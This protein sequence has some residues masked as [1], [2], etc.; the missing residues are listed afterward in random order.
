[1]SETMDDETAGVENRSEIVFLYDAE[2]ANPNGNPLSA[3]DRPRIDENTQQAVVTDVRLKRFIRDQLH[4]DNLGVYIRNPA[5]EGEQGRTRDDLF[6]DLLDTTQDEIKEMDSEELFDRF[7]EKATDVRYFGATLSFDD[8]VQDALEE[9]DISTPQYTGP[10]QFSHGRSMHEVVENSESKK[11]SVTIQSDAD[12]DQG[13]F[14]EDN[15]LQYALINFHGILNE[16][17][18][19]MTDLRKSDVSRLDTVIWRALKNQTLTRSKM[20][21]QPRMYLRVEFDGGYHEGDLDDLLS[22]NEAESAPPREM[23]DISD[24]TIEIGDLV[25]QLSSSPVSERINEIRVCANKY[26]T[27]SSNGELGGPELLYTEL[28]KAGPVTIVEPYDQ[29]TDR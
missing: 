24:V 26:V 18:G 5:K 19:S 29:S 2:D 13:T 15:R 9:A 4:D 10:L 23:R 6:L 14:A 11:L 17:N 16:V 12:D 8:K 3:N 22:I 1:M 21:H 27:F 25:D 7:L 28:E 20:G